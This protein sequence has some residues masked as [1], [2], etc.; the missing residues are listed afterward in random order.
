MTFSCFSSK[1]IRALLTND[2]T[3]I[4][5]ILG[6]EVP[7]IKDR[8]PPTWK[9]A[10][11][12]VGLKTGA[13]FAHYSFRVSMSVWPQAFT[14]CGRTKKVQVLALKTWTPKPL[15][16]QIQWGNDYWQGCLP[17]YSSQ[18][19]SYHTE[20]HL[21]SCKLRQQLQCN[22]NNTLGD[23]AGSSSIVKWPDTLF[24][25]EVEFTPC[26]PFLTLSVPS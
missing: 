8:H 23:S 20:G 18:D 22:R 14:I 6:G 12:T 19:P 21:L 5:L 4:T 16:C 13:F 3:Q 17:A 2:I 15:W 9:M 10:S 25:A 26:L 24:P 11:L 7:W 1:S